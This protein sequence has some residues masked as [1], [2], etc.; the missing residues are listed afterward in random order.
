MQEEEGPYQR[1]YKKLLYADWHN[2]EDKD[3]EGII[4]IFKT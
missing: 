3:M 2:E 1:E 4:N